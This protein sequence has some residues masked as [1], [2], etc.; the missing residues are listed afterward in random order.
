[1]AVGLGGGGG[2]D[3]RSIVLASAAAVWLDAFPTFQG[4]TVNSK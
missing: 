4:K 2:G 3:T 1:M